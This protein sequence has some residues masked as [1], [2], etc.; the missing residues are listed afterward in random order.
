MDLLAQKISLFA[1][2]ARV[3]Y[4]GKL[5]AKSD[6]VNATHTG[7]L[8][9]SDRTDHPRRVGRDDILLLGAGMVPRIADRRNISAAVGHRRAARESA[10]AALEVETRDSAPQSRSTET[11]PLA[12][13]C[14]R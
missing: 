8:R 1:P 14:S 3:L 10:A 11:R 6:Q 12:I 2:R 13:R 5:R 9:D 4:E 7:Q